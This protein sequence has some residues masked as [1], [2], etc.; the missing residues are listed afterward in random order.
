MLRLGRNRCREAIAEYEAVR[1]FNRYG[2]GVLNGLGQC[3]LFTGYPDEAIS[4]LEQAIRLR[5]GDQQ[6]G[7]LY[8]QMGQAYLLQSRV[9][10]AIYWLEKARSA[11]PELA[12]LHALLASAYGLKGDTEPA[13]AELAD[14][15]RL[16][17]AGFLSSLARV[18]AGLSRIDLFNVPKVRGW[19]EAT[20]LVGLRKAGVPEE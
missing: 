17:P 5:P 2:T 11:M 19:F 3:K 13:A 1:A 15:R 10:E 9:D 18:K 20:Y 14:A 16:G 8:F 6:I 12:Y 4:A 7:L